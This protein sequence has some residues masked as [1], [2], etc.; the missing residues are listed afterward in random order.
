MARIRTAA[1]RVVGAL[2][3]IAGDRGETLAMYDSLGYLPNLLWP[4]S[5]SEKVVRR[6][7]QR[8]PA[9]WSELSD[10]IRVRHHVAARVGE[11]FLNPLHLVTA[12]PD[13]ID[14]EALPDRFVVKASHGSGWNVIVNDKTSI[15]ADEIRARCRT[16]LAMR[17]GVDTHERWYASIQPRILVEQFI[18]DWHVRRAARLQV[19]GVSR[20]RRS[21]CKWTSVDSRR[22][23][24]PIYHRHWRRQSW[25]C[26]LSR[27]AQTVPGPKK[28]DRDDSRL[29]SSLR[30]LIL[31]FVRVDLIQP[32][33][34][35][36]SLFGEL[37]LRARR[38]VGAIPSG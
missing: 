14:F 4:R 13:E 6:K 32:D 1:R 12:S 28:L 15:S 24:E 37:T 22:T 16:W 35:D 30:R 21:S 18:A 23:H 31:D 3:R 11:R 38:R 29:P 5:F 2:G 34:N 19:L 25:G 20:R 26:R 17:Y 8:P 27:L 10:K 33:D 9:I 36:R 7:L